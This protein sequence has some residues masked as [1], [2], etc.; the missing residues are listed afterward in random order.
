ARRAL[1]VRFTTSRGGIEAQL[2]G[3]RAPCN[4]QAVAYL[5][6]KG[7]YDNTPCPRIVSGGIWVIQCGSGGDTTAGGPTFTLPDENL[8]FASYGRGTIAM[9]NVGTPNTASSQFFFI[10]RKTDAQLPKS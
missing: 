10:T 1:A 6:D 5:I 2:V 3:D 4:V 8:A 7:F 9:A